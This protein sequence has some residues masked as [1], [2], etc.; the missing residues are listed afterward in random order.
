MKKAIIAAAM[1]HVSVPELAPWALVKRPRFSVT[2]TRAT[3]VERA[4]EEGFDD[5]FL[6]LADGLLGAGLGPL[7]FDRVELRPLGDLDFDLE[8]PSARAL[9]LPRRV[10]AMKEYY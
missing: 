2:G 7:D 10:V 1:G 3:S 8:S 6:D 5:P 4:L 9:D